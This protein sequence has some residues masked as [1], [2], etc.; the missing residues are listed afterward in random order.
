MKPKDLER[1]ATLMGLEYNQ[2][3][4]FPHMVEKGVLV[5]NGCNGQRFL[6]DSNW[7]DDKIHHELGKALIAFGKRSKCLE[8]NSVISINSD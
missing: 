2:K 6:I 3:D 1:M 8:I 7:E 4:N 5:F